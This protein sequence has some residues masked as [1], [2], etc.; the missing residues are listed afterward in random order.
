MAAIDDDLLLCMYG[1]YTYDP[2]RYETKFMLLAVFVEK[3]DGVWTSHP[4]ESPY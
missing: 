1:N 4:P 3:V 2:S